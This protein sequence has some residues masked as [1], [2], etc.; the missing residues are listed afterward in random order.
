MSAWY[1]DHTR[2]IEVAWYLQGEGELNTPGAV[3]DFFEKPWHWTA[4]HDEMV[5]R[6]MDEHI[7]G[8]KVVAA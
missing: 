2:L 6:A 7:R 1:D 8:L 4:E 3:I 5:G